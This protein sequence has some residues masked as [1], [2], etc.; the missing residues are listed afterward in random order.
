MPQTDAPKFSGTWKALFICP[1]KKIIGDLA[2]LL[3]KHLPTFS[4]HDLNA[5]PT[6]HQLADVLNVEAPN[7]CLLEISEPSER[8]LA[9]IA[10]LLRMNAR[11][12][13]IVVLANTILNWCCAA[14]A[15]APA[16]F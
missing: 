6:R 12:P 10:D 9:V 5:Y 15:R 13:I 3:R 8:G 11:L 16:I 4:G 1:N 2:P 14:Y 7:L